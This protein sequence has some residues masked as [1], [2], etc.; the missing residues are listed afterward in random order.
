MTMTTNIM[1]SIRQR[2]SVRNYTGEP[3]SR[4]HRESINRYISQCAAPFGAKVRIQLVQSDTTT[5]H[6]RLGTYGVISGA[7]DFLA[8]VYEKAHLAEESAAY[9]FEQVLLFCTSLGLGTCWLG[10][11]FSRKDFREQVGLQSGESLRIVSPVGYPVDKK[12]LWDA[13]IGAEKNHTSCKPFGSLFF[14][15]DFDTP[16]TEEAA[17]IYLQPLTMLRLAP[18]ANNQQSWRVVKDQ[19]SLH[20]YYQKTLS[21]FGT[22]DMGIALSHFGETCRELQILGHF[23]TAPPTPSPKN[24][25]YSISWVEEKDNLIE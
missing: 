10:G 13:L 24:T 15:N 22:F 12:R 1:D 20:F 17:G 14:A 8:L 4:E 11:S 21:G 7:R 6:T 23:E 19:N 2:R 9:V 25:I 3:L 18:S 16:L 5:E